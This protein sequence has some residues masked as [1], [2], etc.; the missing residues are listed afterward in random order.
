MSSP[1]ELDVVDW[2][3]RIFSLYAEARASEPRAGWERW[4]SERERL[5]R[6]HP[7]SPVPAERRTRAAADRAVLVEWTTWARSRSSARTASA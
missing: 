6:E 1:T 4:R 2:R 5:Y 7:A 3:R